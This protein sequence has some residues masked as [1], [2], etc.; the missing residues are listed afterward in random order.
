MVLDPELRWKAQVTKAVVKAT[1][2]V[3]MYRRL[4]KQHSGLTMDLMR[5]LYK[6]VGIPKMTYAAD[7]WYIPLEKAP[8]G[9]KRVRSADALKWMARVQ[10]IAAIAIT[11][12]LGLTA[13]DMLDAHAGI[14]P[15]E[16]HRKRDQKFSNPTPIQ[17]MAQRYDTD[18]TKTEKI[19]LKAR[20]PDHHPT[21]T[22]QIAKS[23]EDSIAHEKAD[24]APIR[25][26][27][28]GSG[29]DEQTGAAA[30]LYRGKETEP[31]HVVQYHLGLKAH[32]STY[33]AKWVGVILGVWLL[34][35]K[36]S[37]RREIGTTKISIYTDNQSIL[38]AMRSG[39]P[40][41]AQ[42]LQDEFFK[43]VDMVSNDGQRREKF[44]LKW[45]SAHSN[46][47]R[48]ERVDEEAKKAARGETSF[49]MSLPLLLRPG[50]PRSIL[51]LK[52]EVKKEAK[53]RWI[54]IWEES[55]RSE[56]FKEI[57]TVPL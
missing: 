43:L 26:Y 1:T 2:W 45:I 53:K 46:M 18:P 5:Q 41:P 25:I 3:M 57:D 51:S 7:I 36:S 28:G 15:M 12:A 54:G 20:A 49:V 8:G 13:G 21:F 30:I 27:P 10:R 33:K 14:E 17:M 9:K 55:K 52:E 31:E 22:I 50:L 40:E 47:T 6:A 39:R 42:Y 37:I 38:K 48:N 23:R 32:H 44:T 4:T 35:S 19:S 16:A 24:D 56:G 34:I 11:G 29:I